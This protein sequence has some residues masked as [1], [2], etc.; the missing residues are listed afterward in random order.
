[1]SSVTQH[2]YVQT[3]WSRDLKF[4][5]NFYHPLCV[6]CD[7]SCIVCHISRV[8]CKKKSKQRAGTQEC[9]SKLVYLK[10]IDLVLYF[11]TFV[12]K[13]KICNWEPKKSMLFLEIFSFLHGCSPIHVERS[14]FLLK[15]M[16][17]ISPL[18]LILIR[19]CPHGLE[20]NHASKWF[21]DNFPGIIHM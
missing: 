13:M 6:M 9:L 7:L 20:N 11:V 21:S 4:L 3:V 8:K 19:T 14:F 2:H 15:S 18:G 10:M 17:H 1:M 16:W 12:W 5:D